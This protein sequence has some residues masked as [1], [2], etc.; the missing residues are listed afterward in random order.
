MIGFCKIQ[1]KICIFFAPPP[2]PQK[3]GTGAPI[4]TFF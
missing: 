3:V 1:E 2:P 4:P